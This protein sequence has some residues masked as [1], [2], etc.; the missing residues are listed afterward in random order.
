MPGSTSLAPPKLSQLLAHFIGRFADHAVFAQRGEP[1]W[2]LTAAAPALVAAY[3]A[4]LGPDYQVEGEVAIHATARVEAG[5]IVKGPAA[6]GPRAFV[7]ATA[8]LRGGV[9]LDEDCAIGPAAELKSS[10]LFNG[11]K[12]AH[13]SFV[14]DSILGAGVNCEAGCVIANH[15]NEWA[16]KRIRIE[17]AGQVIETG[18]DKFGALIGE[19][20]RIGANAVVAPGALILPHAVI[21]RL[22]LVDQSPKP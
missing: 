10:F 8:Y 6:I 15:R 11:S 12:L 7:A 17:F 1:P 19:G 3:L 21:A 4:T 16:D 13:L 22:G 20:A 18:V 5:A 2:R 9:F 14:G